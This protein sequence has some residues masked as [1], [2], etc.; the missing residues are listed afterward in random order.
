M[1]I[2]N[3]RDLER[4]FPGYI[5]EIREWFRTIKTYDGKKPN[6]FG[7]Q[8]RVLS[9]ER[10]IEVIHETN[11]QYQDLLSGRVDNVSNLWLPSSK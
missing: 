3:I 1:G 11:E 6:E 2:K 8:G 4:D 9:N 7:Y 5:S 10:A